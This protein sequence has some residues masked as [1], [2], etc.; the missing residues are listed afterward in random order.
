[1]ILTTVGNTNNR[2]LKYYNCLWERGGEEG[3]D[4]LVIIHR[5]CIRVLFENKFYEKKTKSNFCNAGRCT[6]LDGHRGMS[7]AD[8]LPCAVVVVAAG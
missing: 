4:F 1:M 7:A 6:K 5:K 3:D 8:R 2:V